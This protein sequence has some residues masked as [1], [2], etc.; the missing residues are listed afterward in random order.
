MLMTYRNRRKL[1]YVFLWCKHGEWNR[2]GCVF[3]VGGTGGAE[4]K[5]RIVCSF[6]F[7]IVITHSNFFFFGFFFSFFFIVY[8]LSS[9]SS[10]QKGRVLGEGVFYFL[11]E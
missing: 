5:E 11:T 6:L 3:L 4:L 10:G 8:R 1:Q 9:F 2:L 7:E